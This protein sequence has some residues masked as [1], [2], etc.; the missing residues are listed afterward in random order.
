[1]PALYFR[2]EKFI[3]IFEFLYY[4]DSINNDTSSHSHLSLNLQFYRTS[5]DVLPSKNQALCEYCTFVS[6]LNIADTY[7]NYLMR[8]DSLLK[9]HTHLKFVFK[10][11]LHFST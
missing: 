4:L 8:R 1:M 10:W 7:F 6:K 3:K 2:L 9:T 11:A 5:I